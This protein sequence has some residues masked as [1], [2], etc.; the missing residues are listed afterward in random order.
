MK[1]VVADH[2]PKAPKKSV[3]L[4]S[5][6]SHKLTNAFQVE[7]KESYLLKLGEIFF[8]LHII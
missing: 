6:E 3:I 2:F 4:A 7:Q 5:F 8:A 1:I